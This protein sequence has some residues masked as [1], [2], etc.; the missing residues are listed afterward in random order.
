MAFLAIPPSNAAVIWPPAGISLA[1]VLVCGYSVLP[2]VFIGDLVIAIEIFGFA[3]FSAIVFS[4]MVGFQA[5][6]AAWFGGFLINGLLGKNNPLLD[7]RSIVMFLLLGGPVSHIG[8]SVL[9]IATELWLGAINPGDTMSSIFTWWLGGSIGVILFTPLVLIFIAQPRSAWQPRIVPVF[10]PL[11]FLCVAGV[12]FFTFIKT[13][14]HK[15]VRQLFAQTASVVHRQIV[16][17]GMELAEKGED[18]RLFISAYGGISEAEFR[19][20]SQAALNERFEIAALSWIPGPRLNSAVVQEAEKVGFIE[21]YFAYDL[22]QKLDLTARNDWYTVLTRLQDRSAVELIEPFTVKSANGTRTLAAMALR[23]EHYQGK[24]GRGGANNNDV[25][26]FLTLFFD[27]D[28]W[29]Y[30]TMELAD[31]HN[32]TLQLSKKTSTDPKAAGSAAVITDYG[33]EMTMPVNV[34]GNVWMF[35]YQPTEQFVNSHTTFSYWWVFIAGF[36]VISLFGFLLLSV[37]GQTLQTQ[38]L[39]NER[40]NQLNNERRLLESILNNIRE[41]IVACDR[42]GRLTMLNRAAREQYG[43]EARS[44]SPREWADYYRLLEADGKTQ[45]M[46]MNNPLYQA[47]TGKSVAAFEMMMRLPD[48]SLI[49]LSVNSQPLRDEQNKIVGAVASFQDIT[50]QKKNVNELKKLSLAVQHSP[51]GIMMTDIAGRIEYVN[52]KFEQINGYTL[53][54]IRGKCPSFLKSGRTSQQ[55]YKQLWETLLNGGDWQGEILNQKKNGEYYW[56][57]QFISPVKDEQG[58][59]THFV[60]ILEDVTEVRKKSEMI[61]YQASHDDLTGLLN[62]RECEKRLERVITSTRTSNTRHVFCFLDLDKFKI[63]NDTCGHLA[64]DDLLRGV[65]ELLG[66]QLRQRDTLARLGG[67]EFGIIMEHCQ[68][69]Q[70]REIAEKI[71]LEIS[72]YNFHWQE[73]CFKIGVS[74]GLTEVNKLSGD[75]A[76]VIEQADQACYR[77]KKQGRGQVAMFSDN[78][79]VPF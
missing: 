73:H 31:R 36:C 67:D 58:K 30:K 48:E 18:L 56:S 59:L 43:L 4:L 66:R 57:K 70:A 32:I 23:L 65:A 55:T 9:A 14:E 45:L 69:K 13:D 72:S 7:N 24:E 78:N 11:I 40:T 10:L 12:W 52:D 51:S 50:S 77:V 3:D 5:C 21:P 19:I 37:T 27:Y 61:S 62:R 79:I 25:L 29:L 68:L 34:L 49:A 33:F 17:E 53:A 76:T 22:L 8:P 28:K 46:L 16:E 63:V 71:C 41:G 74:I 20:L 42:R 2:A 6:W 54:E 15:R 26:G 38:N 44:L 47:L 75:F 60:C 1:A 39:V 35:S 64:G